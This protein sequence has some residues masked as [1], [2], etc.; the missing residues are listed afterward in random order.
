[1]S[2]VY[3]KIKYH[4]NERDGLCGRQKEREDRKMRGVHKGVEGKVREVLAQHWP[5][6]ENE[7]HRQGVPE[8]RIKQLCKDK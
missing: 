7:V 3:I 2:C 4:E 1:M 5:C 8:N 6:C